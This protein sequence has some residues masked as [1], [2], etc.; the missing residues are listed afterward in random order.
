MLSA[1]S[2]PPVFS[3]VFCWEEFE[4]AAPQLR[5]LRDSL[6][7]RD[8]LGSLW[9][10]IKNSLLS[11]PAPAFSMV[12]H[13]ISSPGTSTLH[14][15]CC[16]SASTCLDLPIHRTLSSRHDG[17]LNLGTYSPLNSTAPPRQARAVASSNSPV[18]SV[19][20]WDG[21]PTFFIFVSKG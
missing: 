5:D 17:E 16:C 18:K 15:P 20:P 2:S 8:N 3:L 6:G 7:I 12:V 1:A 13:L 4:A 14:L 9:T 10:L 19:T 11:S 21:Y